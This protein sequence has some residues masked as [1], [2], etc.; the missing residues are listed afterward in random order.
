MHNKTINLLKENL[1]KAF[2]HLSQELNKI[3]G[4]KATPQLLDDIKVEA[5]GQSMPLNQVASVTSVNPTLLAVNVWDKG[6]VETIKKAIEKSSLGMNPIIDGNTLKIPIPPPSEERRKEL[7]KII[8]EKCENSK[9]VVRNIRK[10][11]LEELHKL[12]EKSAISEDEFDSTQK[13][14][15]KLIDEYNEKIENLKSAKEEDLL[16]I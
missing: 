2:S 15:Q 16:K 12:K 11:S 9:V 14:V 10:E 8:N 6:N 4:T 5:Y 3:R 1:E 7:V 13:E